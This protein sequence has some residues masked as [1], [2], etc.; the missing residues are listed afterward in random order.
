MCDQIHLLLRVSTGPTVSPV[1]PSNGVDPISTSREDGF[2]SKLGESLLM[3]LCA[4]LFVVLMGGIHMWRSKW[5]WNLNDENESMATKPV[6]SRNSRHSVTAESELSDQFVRDDSGRSDPMKNNQ[7]LLEQASP[8][9]PPAERSDE[10]CYSK[11][12]FVQ[13]RKLTD[14][15][16]TSDVEPPFFI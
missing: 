10:K 2:M 11:E 4:F 6:Q 1:P 14:L 5:C 8:R 15:P 3:A 7:H 13:E 12:Q 16:A 9:R